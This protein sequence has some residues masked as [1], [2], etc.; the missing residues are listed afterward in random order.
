MT[1]RLNRALA[2]MVCAL[3]LAASRGLDLTPL[4]AMAGSTEYPESAY[5]VVIILSRVVTKLGTLSAI[6][7]PVIESLFSA[8]LAFLQDFYRRINEEGSAEMK[9]SCP[10]CK[11]SFEV[12]I[13]TL[14]E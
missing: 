4:R 8:D 7:P 9:V 3:L 13:G 14:G 5:L 10:A 1:E 2:V 12:D 6:N 11:H